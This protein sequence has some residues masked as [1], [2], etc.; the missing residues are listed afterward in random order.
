MSPEM[1][2]FEAIYSLRAMRRLKPDPVPDKV[3]A[4]VLEAAIQAPS[5]VNRQPWRFLV[6]RDRA[7]KEKI[8]EYYL[9]AWNHTY[10]ASATQGQSLDPATLRVLRSADYLARH[11]ADAPLLVLVCLLGRPPADPIRASSRYGSVYPAVQNLMLTARA[12][13]LGTTLTTVYKRYDGE[14]KE[15]LGIPE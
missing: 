5:S 8:A 13:G 14:I 7:L 9:E 15:L 1:D 6:I 2:V 3:V 10:G 11:M 12:L 4:R